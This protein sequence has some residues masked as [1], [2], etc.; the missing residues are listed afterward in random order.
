MTQVRYLLLGF[1][2]FASCLT[3][4]SRDSVLPD[5]QADEFSAFAFIQIS[6]IHFFGGE[7]E[8]RR[9]IN[10][11]GK[12]AAEQNAAFILI[13]GD[14]EPYNINDL[15]QL[16]QALP[17]PV[18]VVIG[19]HDLT[20]NRPLPLYRQVFGPDDYAFTYHNCEFIGTNSEALFGL[21]GTTETTAQWQR[22]ENRVNAAR[23]AR[24]SR[25]FVFGHYPLY[26]DHPTEGANFWNFPPDLRQ[27]FD[28][29]AQAG[30]VDAYLAGHLHENMVYDAEAP[31]VY[32]SDSLR[33]PSAAGYGYSYFRVTEDMIWRSYVPLDHADTTAPFAP[34][35][36][37][38][39]APTSATLRLEWMASSDNMG[40]AYYEVSRDGT[41]LGRTYGESYTIPATAEA[42]QHTYT[43]VARDLAGNASPPCTFTPAALS[44]GPFLEDVSATAVTIHWSTLQPTTT[45]LTMNKTGDAA[46]MFVSDPAA[47]VE[48]RVKLTNLSSSTRYDYRVGTGLQV[49]AEGEACTFITH[50][51]GERCAARAWAAYE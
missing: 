29:I 34:Q 26:Y 43:I 44:G 39:S 50:K 11:V 47:N 9:R 23:T 19:N 7:S 17:V 16:L 38:I 25:T 6:D 22:L 1:I 8:I 27:R 20:E 15:H 40:V 46:M 14:L 49:L 42:A 37:A 45:Y 2:W 41:A 30:Q 51:Q 28:A 5:A 24:R 35:S 3:A 36:L 18:F 31:T 21:C 32:V 4:W 33:T 48:H 12:I 13:T 10:A